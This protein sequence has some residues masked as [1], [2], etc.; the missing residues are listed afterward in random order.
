MLSKPYNHSLLPPSPSLLGPTDELLPW[1]ASLSADIEEAEEEE[2][3]TD[4]KGDRLSYGVAV[5]EKTLSLSLTS[6]QN[7]IPTRLSMPGI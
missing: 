7:S 6:N 5:Q 2:K 1:G 3:W 4:V